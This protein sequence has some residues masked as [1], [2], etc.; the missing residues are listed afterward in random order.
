MQQ[1]HK[2]A[3]S[4]AILDAASR[5]RKAQKIV[6]VLAQHTNVPQAH[7]LDIGTGAGYIAQHLASCARQV[8]SV[9]VVDERHV[10]AGYHFVPVTDET[11]PFANGTFDIVV[12]N[13]VIEHVQDQRRHVTEVLRVL[14]PGGVAYFAT[15]NR[16]WLIDPHYRLPFINW[17]PRRL[18]TAYLRL[19]KGQQWDIRPITT[20][21][22]RQL[23]Q[24]QRVDLAVV[25]MMKNPEKYYL[26]TA[27][28]LLHLTRR[29]PRPLLHIVSH[30]L[31]TILLL[32]TK[33]TPDTM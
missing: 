17:L 4:H 16:N 1:V 7:I 24:P 5:K 25:G 29:S 3:H 11:M 22:F 13:H 23:A 19:V 32:V 21:Y 27:S 33:T 31:P 14:K 30:G 28:P 9:D 10:T 6:S 18:A 12:S 26:D 20:R 15:P 8:T 2:S